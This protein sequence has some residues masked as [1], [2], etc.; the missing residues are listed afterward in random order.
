MSSNEIS[1]TSCGHNW[2]I[3][4]RTWKKMVLSASKLLWTF[5]PWF[6][7]PTCFA[8]N[9]SLFHLT[10]SLLFLK[11]ELLLP[12]PEAMFYGQ[13]QGP[14]LGCKTWTPS[15]WITS[16]WPDWRV[17]KSNQSMRSWGSWVLSTWGWYHLKLMALHV[18]PELRKNLSFPH[19]KHL[20]FSLS[21][22]LLFAACH[23]VPSKHR[24]PS[25]VHVLPRRHS[26]WIWCQIFSV[27]CINDRFP[28][29]PK[30]LILI[31]F[32]ASSFD[33]LSCHDAPI[34]LRCWCFFSGLHLQGL[35]L[36]CSPDGVY[37]AFPYSRGLGWSG[38][39]WVS[40]IANPYV[41]P[42]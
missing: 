31:I 25:F 29:Y 7:W 27:I 1:E 3:W 5:G 2:K 13:D 35:H 17:I 24:M 34:T 15:W 38:L 37:L 4:K 11:S 14:D 16:T 19:L 21:G 36:G 39:G 26:D 22:V 33:D 28:T 41:K 18:Q 8:F 12:A 32:N 20:G 30:S 10:F 40:G 42:F 6:R 23:E 9:K